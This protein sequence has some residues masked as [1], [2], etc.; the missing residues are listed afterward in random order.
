MTVMGHH[1][2]IYVKDHNVLNLAHKKCCK[3]SDTKGGEKPIFQVWG[4]EKMW[5]K[6]KIF[7]K[8]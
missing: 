5:V 2:D 3:I 1:S 6:T 4:G 7:P 8:S